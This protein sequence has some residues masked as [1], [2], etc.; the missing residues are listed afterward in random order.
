MD[1]QAIHDFLSDVAEHQMAVIRDDDV[2]RHL[3]FAKPGTSCYHFDLVTWPGVLCYTGDMGTYVFTRIRDMFEFFRTDRQHNP[4]KPL[5]INRGYWSEKLI[6]TDCSGKRGG[7]ATEFDPDQFRRVINEYRVGWMRSM[8]QDGHDA[9]ARR[10]L[11]EAVDHQVLYALDN[12]GE[13]AQRDAYEF[14]HRIE[15]GG[16]A[17]QFEDLFEH[18]FTRFTHSFTWCCYALTWGIQKYDQAKAQENAA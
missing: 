2:N 16:H 15:N 14:S 12:H 6:A 18:D 3:R 4:D 7:A 5:P 13:G 8:K 9:D 11:W 17:Y 1:D 10:E